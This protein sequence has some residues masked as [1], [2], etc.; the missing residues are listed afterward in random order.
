MYQHVLDGQLVKET[1]SKYGLCGGF[2]VAFTKI[3]C[4]YNLIHMLHPFCLQYS[5]FLVDEIINRI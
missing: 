4:S 5:I 2:F 3:F 1:S